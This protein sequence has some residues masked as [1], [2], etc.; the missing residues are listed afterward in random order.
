MRSPHASQMFIGMPK[1]RGV[2]GFAAFFDRI[3]SENNSPR[4]GSRGPRPYM[5]HD[6]TFVG[7]SLKSGARLGALRNS[8]PRGDA[9]HSLSNLNPEKAKKKAR[10][11]PACLDVLRAL[12]T[13]CLEMN[14]PYTES[15]HFAG[16]IEGTAGERTRPPSETIHRELVYPLIR[17]GVI[18][19]RSFAVRCPAVR[20]TQVN[21]QWGLR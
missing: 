1:R 8:F 17:A 15:L 2:Q 3:R 12:R 20:P 9:S 5:K 16:A 14:I 4:S 21:R 6:R 10:P 13:R 7:G 18:A 19:E 11:F